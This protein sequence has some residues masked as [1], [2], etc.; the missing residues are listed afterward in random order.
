[1]IVSLGMYDGFHASDANDA[2]TAA[3][4]RRLGT[5][6]TRDRGD[7]GRAWLSPALVFG[8]TCSFPFATRLAGVVDLVA[9][10]YYDVPGVRPGEHRAFLVARRDDPRPVTRLRDGT[11]AVNDLESMT[12]H[13]LL[14]ATIGTGDLAGEVLLTGSHLESLRAIAEGGAD[15][16]SIDCVTHA[17]LTR[18]LPDLVA[19][20]RIVDTTPPTLGLPFVVARALG[21][22]VRDAVRRVL[23]EV[24][25]EEPVACRALGLAGVLPFDADEFVRDV[26]RHAS[27]R[28][29]QQTR[30]AAPRA[31]P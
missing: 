28:R 23:P 17:M 9:T 5:T 22:E 11:I 19:A 13:V 10:P 14:S 2:L 3:L 18:A 26:A 6:L 30:G 31:G 20:T 1:V 16:A 27:G 8:Q 29:T 21:E 4:E 25:R 7:V 12:G 15:L 24:L